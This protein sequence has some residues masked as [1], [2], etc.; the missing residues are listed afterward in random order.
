MW[1]R[2]GYLVASCVEV[3]SCDRRGH[4]SGVSRAEAWPVVDEVYWSD[5]ERLP[6][7]IKHAYR[8]I[9]NDPCDFLS[10]HVTRSK[11][12]LRRLASFIAGQGGA[13]DVLAVEVDCN[14][15]LPRCDDLDVRWYGFEPYS[16]GEWSLLSVVTDSAASFR[17]G[18]ANSTYMVSSPPR[19][20]VWNLRRTTSR[21][22]SGRVARSRLPMTRSSMCFELGSPKYRYRQAPPDGDEFVASVI[23]QSRPRCLLRRGSSPRSPWRLI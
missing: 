20:S 6:P 11:Q 1:A 4:Y 2:Y 8:E 14:W 21:L 17:P 15:R 10:L 5:P 9:R 23:H 16:R 22:W 7:D 13:F 18:T 12:V 19:S 3:P